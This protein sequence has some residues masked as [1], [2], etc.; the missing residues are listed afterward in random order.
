MKENLVDIRDLTIGY[1]TKYG[2]LVHVLRNVNLQIKRGETLGLV[3]E[4]GCGKSTL[5]Q[6]MM[7]FLRSGSK[8]LS[9]QV[10]YNDIDN[11]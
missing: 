10:V 11:R 3:G 8:I 4:S 7:G 9:G 2:R 6:A 1:H 5:G